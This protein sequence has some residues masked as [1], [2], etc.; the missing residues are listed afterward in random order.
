VSATLSPA[1]ARELVDAR[2]RFGVRLGL[3]RMWRLLDAL[4]HPERRYGA[5]HIV[6][7]NG[8]STAART[9]EGLLQASGVRTGT[10]LS[11]HVVSLA[12]RFRVGGAELDVGRVIAPVLGAVAA[13]DT[14]AEEPVTQF[15]L[16]TIAA[17][18]AFAEAS[19]DVAIVEAGL[20]GRYDATNV[21]DAEIIV[22]TNVA[23][24]H[25]EHLGTTR[26]EIA[27]EKLAVIKPGATVVL[28]ESEWGAAAEAHGATRVLCADS[29][30]ELARISAEAHLGERLGAVD[31]PD[32]SL[33]GR[34]ERIAEDPEEIWDGAHN[35]HAVAW[36]KQQRAG[37]DHVVVLSILADKDVDEM[38]AG[39]AKLGSVLVA[40]TSTNPRALTA[41]Q[42][43][44]RAQSLGGFARIEAVDDPVAARLRGREIAN[45][46]G[47]AVLISG[48]LYL[49][50]DLAVVRS[51]RVP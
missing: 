14:E 12:E 39:F 3:E 43:M 22:L 2:E 4:D 48:S 15:E 40:T 46:A 45:A 31:V 8:K 26:P 49:L 13:V 42:L 35:P 27:S 17:L 9:I 10:Y 50:H 33:P 30:A 32:P 51:R 6:G 7:T 36:L 11:P 21:L 47:T 18:N 44:E 34:C 38:L 41:R 1:E 37:I 28:G 23:L 5:I 24:D 29:P 25:Q 20:G 16:L 19:I